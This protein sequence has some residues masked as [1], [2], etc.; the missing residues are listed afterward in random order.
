MALVGE[1]GVRSRLRERRA[2]LDRCAG[3]REASHGPVPIG[4]G[5]EGTPEMAGDRI[6]VSARDLLEFAGQ[7][8][9]ARVGGQVGAHEPDSTQVG[10]GAIASGQAG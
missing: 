9:L 1:A 2:V 10:P 4:T 7:D 3:Q 6:P 5:T 8:L